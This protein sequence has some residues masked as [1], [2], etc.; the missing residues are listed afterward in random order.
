VPRIKLVILDLDNTLYDWVGFYIPS[1]LAMV[2]ELAGITGID[3]EQLKASFKRV[4]ER[5]HSTEYAFSIEELD[6]LRDVDCALTTAQ[7]LQKYDAAIHAFRKKRIQLLRL[8]D[9]VADTLAELK[10]RNCALA[11]L[12]DTTVFYGAMRLRQLGIEHHFD[13]ICAPM[14]HG[15]PEG[16]NPS[17]VRWDNSSQRYGTSIPCVLETGSIRKPEPELVEMILN[18]TEVASGDA[19]LVGDSLY[20]DIKMAQATGVS[21][22]FARYG[23]AMTSD[24]YKELLKITCWTAEDVAE[25]ERLTAEVVK[26]TFV[27]DW[28]AELM[29]VLDQLESDTASQG[30]TLGRS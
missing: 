8:Y 18:R 28:F 14:D 20:R 1:F 25:Y 22:V 23:N 3:A 10:R 4:H 26:P 11:A 29:G 19:V 21:D 9:G 24:H 30:F 5:H 16:I 12:T 17:D 27:V 13:V 7:K 15:I 6:V 2:G